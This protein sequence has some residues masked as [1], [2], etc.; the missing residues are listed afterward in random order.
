MDPKK[1][2]TSRCPRLSKGPL[3]D[4]FVDLH[5]KRDIMDTKDT[6]G[7]TKC[8]ESWEIVRPITFTRVFQDDAIKEVFQDDDET[9]YA[10]TR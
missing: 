4:V 10:T 9:Y 1:A 8:S 5:W 2:G 3:D 6:K 7:K